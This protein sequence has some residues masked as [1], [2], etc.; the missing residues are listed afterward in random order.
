MIG[1]SLMKIILVTAVS[2]SIVTELPA[3]E[4]TPWMDHTYQSY[5]MSVNLADA[6]IGEVFS[7]RELGDDYVVTYA[8]PRVNKY[9]QAE[10]DAHNMLLVLQTVQ[11]NNPDKTPYD[12]ENWDA[13]VI[14]LSRNDP[15]ISKY[16]IEFCDYRPFAQH[17]LTTCLQMNGD[18]V[19]FSMRLIDSNRND[20]YRNSPEDCITGHSHNKSPYVTW[21]DP[22]DGDGEHYYTT[23]V[24]P[25]E[26][27]YGEDYFICYDQE[28][29]DELV[30]YM[31]TASKILQVG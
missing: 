16:N 28:I 8:V 20:D 30:G 25:W 26:I 21:C 19:V 1:S 23:K 29:F 3:P 10:L 4:N 5:A 13:R 15:A 24:E 14:C 22:V 17:G 7:R 18:N 9:L 27:M 31:D 12:D 6:E 11:A 2:T